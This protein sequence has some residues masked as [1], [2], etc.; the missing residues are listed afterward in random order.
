MAAMVVVATL[1]FLMFV[2][3]LA[4]GQATPGYTMHQVTAPGSHET[5]VTAINDRPGARGDVVGHYYDFNDT[6]RRFV[7]WGSTFLDFAPEGDDPC[8][9][10][11]AL[12]NARVIVGKAC[13]GANEG[14]FHTSGFENIGA[15]KEHQT[16]AH[17][18]IAAPGALET[19]ASGNNDAG[20]IVGI[21]TVAESLEQR[22]FV[23][24][25]DVFT[26]VPPLEG[27]EVHPVDVNNKGQ[28][29][30]TLYH[31]ETGDTYGFLFSQGAYTFFDIPDGLYGWVS[32]LNDHGHIV[33]SYFNFEYVLEDDPHSTACC[34]RGF[35]LKDGVYTIINATKDASTAPVGINNAGH[36]AGTFYRPGDFWRGHGFIAVP[37]KK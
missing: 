24:Q 3:F 31:R 22:A 13:F 37:K 21:Y 16:K 18:Q 36:I 11:L 17:V 6:H 15:S 28:V 27:W 2:P 26:D 19:I 5:Y 12:N 7:K 23:L 30:G 32:G 4:W 1:V 34:W 8:H 25:H 29:V 10:P 14:E 9:W 35:L 33:G 20:T